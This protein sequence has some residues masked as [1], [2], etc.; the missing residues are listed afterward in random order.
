M[1]WRRA[2]KKGKKETPKKGRTAC[3]LSRTIHGVPAMSN[4]ARHGALPWLILHLHLE[5]ALL[6]GN[7][8]GLQEGIQELRVNSGLHA[9][10][11]GQIPREGRTIRKG[12]LTDGGQRRWHAEELH[13]LRMR[14][15]R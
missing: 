5:E 11:E 2:V 7:E 4:T 13:T 6:G 12:E 14:R 10:G 15:P 8:F 9:T 1:V 3:A